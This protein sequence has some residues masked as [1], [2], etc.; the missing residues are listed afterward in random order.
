ML[1][2]QQQTKKIGLGFFKPNKKIIIE[3]L[4]Q[5]RTINRMLFEKEWKI[6]NY[7]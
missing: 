3:N 4:L 5:S 7:Y 1:N 6:N 2:Q